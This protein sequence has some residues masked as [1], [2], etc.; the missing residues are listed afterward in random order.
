MSSEPKS[1]PIKRN[2]ARQISVPAPFDAAQ[3]LATAAIGREIFKYAKKQTIFAQGESADAVFYIQKGRVK[4]SVVSK[5]G[6]E[7]VVAIMGPGEFLGEGCL[8]GQP[9]R[10]ATATAMTDSVTMRVDKAEILKVLQQEPAFSKMFI[11]HILARNAREREW[12]NLGG[13]GARWKGGPAQFV[14]V[15]RVGGAGAIGLCAPNH[16]NSAS[17]S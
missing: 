15:I 17:L 4:V 11:S 9:K 14:R 6:K 8:I 7:A 16:A 3:F 2:P 1:K 12:R 5:Q 10:L 13:C